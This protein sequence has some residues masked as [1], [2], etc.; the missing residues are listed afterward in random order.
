MILSHCNSFSSQTLAFLGIPFP[1]K[2]MFALGTTVFAGMNLLSA[3][4]GILT[5]GVG[6]NGSTVAVSELCE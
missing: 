4:Y 5:Q 2:A 1:L 6:K 3:T